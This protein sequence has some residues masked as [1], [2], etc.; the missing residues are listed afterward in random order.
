[1]KVGHI[2]VV[3]L[4]NIHSV[5]G[6][7]VIIIRKERNV[8]QVQDYQDFQKN[9]PKPR[10]YFQKS[11]SKKSCQIHQSMAHHQLRLLVVKNIRTSN[12]RVKVAPAY[13]QQNHYAVAI[14]ERKLPLLAK[15]LVSGWR[16][17]DLSYRR[18]IDYLRLIQC[19]YI[20]YAVVHKAFITWQQADISK[21][22]KF[23]IQIALHL[24]WNERFSSTH[25]TVQFKIFPHI[26][27]SKMQTF[28]LELIAGI[29]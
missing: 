9:R 26:L 5:S 10:W 3:Y 16:D 2:A 23:S 24:W 28:R 13:C 4:V 19:G 6:A 29:K 17:C 25:N 8:K 12:I 21:L 27:N 20:M 1:M 7:N 18:L 14:Q 15:N 11:P 22:P